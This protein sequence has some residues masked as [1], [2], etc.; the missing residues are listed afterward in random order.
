MSAQG[1]E[2]LSFEDRQKAWAGHGRQFRQHHG[3]ADRPTVWEI[4]VEGPRVFTRHGLL[5]GA[6]QETDYTGKVKNA[7]RANAITAEQDAIAEARRDARKKWDF[8]GYDEYVSGVNV[9]R[10]H[11]NI[12]IHHLLTNLPGSFCLYKPKNN[13]D[14]QPKL[15][16][17][18]RKG[19]ALY[20]LKR[21][22]VAKWVVVDYYG[23]VQIY[24]RRSRP[25]QDKE[26]PKELPDGTLDAS[27]VVL[28]SARFP[29]LVE[30]VKKLNLPPGSMMACELV[31]P[32]DDNFPYVSGLTKG[33][34]ARA[35]EDMATKGYPSLYWWDIPFF[36]GEDYVS[37]KTVRERYD[38]IKHYHAV[39][40][41]HPWIQPIEYM[42][43][44]TPEA[45]SEYAKAN[46]IE[47]FVVVDPD[48]VYGDKGW[49]LKGK[50]DRPGTCAKL[51]PRHEDDF[52]AMWDPDKKV[53]EWGTGKHEA[54]KTVQLPDGSSVVHAGVGSIAL[55]QKNDA[56]ELVFTS[57]CSSG[58]DYAF[59]ARLRKESFPFVCQVE[60]TERTYTSDGEKTNALRHPT[61]L[62]CR[63]DKTVDECVNGRL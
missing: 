51:K 20:T 63:D 62:R 7:G 41:T 59:Q 16:E 57:N 11:E 43:F 60:Y 54:N 32:G 44:E 5:D 28:W 1:W 8:E 23:N 13:I 19:K 58:M 4:R 39:S 33:Y 26:G 55:Y 42:E 6:M 29:H 2:N 30:A 36:R 47:G 18:A 40:A 31:L 35:L 53:G 45:A 14:D 21:D 3:R 17:K 48:G 56:G 52:I 46:G 49:N 9:D 27:S 24:S 15:L 61:F 34:T 22:G 37:T 25:W 10:R 12:S 50:P 38:L